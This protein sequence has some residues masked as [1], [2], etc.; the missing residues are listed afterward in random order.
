MAENSTDYQDRIGALTDFS[1]RLLNGGNGKM[2]I[3]KHRQ[4]IDTVTPTEAMQV[5][6]I[7][8]SEGYPNEVVKAHTGK[9]INVFFKSLSSFQWAKPG[10]GHFLYYLMLENRG[11]EKIMREIKSVIKVYYKKGND[12]TVALRDELRLLVE[13]LRNYELHYI[14]KENILFPYLERSFPQYRCLQIMWSFHDDFRRETPH[15]SPCKS[16]NREKSTKLSSA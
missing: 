12:D 8:L 7:M 4:I 6:H 14:K 3:E 11:A 16:Y 10:E 1:R 2:L 13:K 15:I 5:L 9:I